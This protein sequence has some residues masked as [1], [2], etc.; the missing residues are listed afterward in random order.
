MKGLH[1]Q[2]CLISLLNNKILTNTIQMIF[3][4]ID[5]IYIICLRLLTSINRLMYICMNMRTS[6][7]VLVLGYIIEFNIDCSAL[8]LSSLLA[9]SS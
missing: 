2:V 3:R 4:N 8:Q 5:N 1:Q 6:L 9:Y 7:V